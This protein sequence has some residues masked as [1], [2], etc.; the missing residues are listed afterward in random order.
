MKN[1]TGEISYG[2]AEKASTA[3]VLR[4][5]R[6]RTLQRRGRRGVLSEERWS[7]PRRTVRRTHLRSAGGADRFPCA[8]PRMRPEGLG[9]RAR[10][11][12]WFQQTSSETITWSAEAYSIE[13]E[14][15]GVGSAAPFRRFKT[16]TRTS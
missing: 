9:G 3:P 11:S 2:K 16:W 4:P 8:I 14:K 1:H 13:I 6:R 15:G 5:G 7:V 10:R 12:R